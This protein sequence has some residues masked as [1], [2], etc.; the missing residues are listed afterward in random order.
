MA[1]ALPTSRAAGYVLT[2]V[3]HPGAEHE[4]LLLVNRRDGMPGMPKGHQDEGE[5]DQE[6]ARRET[7][8]ETGLSDL[9]VDPWFRSEITYRVRKDGR[10][11]MKTVVYF[12]ARVRNGTVRLSHEHTA[13][14]WQPLPETLRRIT[15]D[16]LRE[17]VRDAALHAKDPGLF[18]LRPV[19]EAEA[20]RHLTSLPR[21]DE[22]LVGHLRGA[23]RIAREIARALAERGLP[24]HPEATAAGTLLHDVGRAVGRHEDHQI[25]GLLHL[26]GTPLAAY[27]FACVTHT[28]KGASVRELREVGVRDPMIDMFRRAIEIEDLT[29]EERCAALADSCMKGPL[30]VDPKERFRDLRARY[31]LS[32]FI[33]LQER[34]T[35]ELREEIARAIGRDPLALVGLA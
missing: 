10:H 32:R 21:A 19:T 1:K 2:R 17:I 25:A 26:R 20:D 29:W 30:A 31:G 4:Y 11:R 34:R 12:R 16:S 14:D 27:D 5:D 3:P 15:F 7:E 13:F 18:R 8:E 24:V 23:A 35:E 28:T 22:A 33:D 9:E 6:T